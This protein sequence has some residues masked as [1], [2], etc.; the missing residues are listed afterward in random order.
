MLKYDREFWAP[1]WRRTGRE[2]CSL[3]INSEEAIHTILDN[4]KVIAVIGLSSNP[5]RP[6]NNVAS[7]MKSAGYT[8]VP[9]N[10]NEKLVLGQKSY[11]S[12]EEIPHEVDLVNIFRRGE[13]AGVHVDE[14]IRIGA[15]A[16]WLQDGVIDNRAA[17]RA[18]DA[19]LIVVMDRCILREHLGR[20]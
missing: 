12:L 8:I 19:G 14:A 17:K 9:V 18:A 20:R 4:C 10:P 6:S 11:S 2:K 3:D 7:Y 16:V 13:E 15:Q 1:R 5:S